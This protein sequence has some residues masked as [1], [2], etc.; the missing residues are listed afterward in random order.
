MRKIRY[1][2][3]HTADSASRNI[4]AAAIDEWHKQRGWKGCGYHYVIVND[5]HRRLKDGTV[6]SADN[7]PCRP[8]YQVGAGVEGANAHSIHICM[9]GDGDTTGWT[10]AQR[11]ALTALCLRLMADYGLQPA[12]VLGHNEVNRLVERGLVG[13]AWRTKKTCPGSQIDMAAFR[14]ELVAATGKATA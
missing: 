4:D 2:F 5:R 10:A 14:A 11:E 12:T 3:I 7:A 9:V 1:I 6:Q 8:V 13:T